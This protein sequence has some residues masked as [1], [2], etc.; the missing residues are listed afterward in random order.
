MARIGLVL[1]LLSLLSATVFYAVVGWQSL[2][3][4]KMS[5]IGIIALVGGVI[6]TFL[7][8]GGLMTLVFYSARR[9]Y[10]DRAHSGEE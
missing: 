10:D 1:I 7:V 9:G 8:G 5:L 2:A 4:I 3:G 6:L